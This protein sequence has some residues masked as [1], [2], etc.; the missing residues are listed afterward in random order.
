LKHFLPHFI[1]EHYSAGIF[2][3]RFH[4]ATLFTDLSGFTRLTE[5]LMQ[6]GPEGA[7]ELSVALNQIFQPLVSLVYQQGGMIPY[8]AG[9]SFTAIFPYD[10]NSTW[11]TE[12]VAHN[13]LYTAQQTLRKFM[14]RTETDLEIGVKI[15]IGAGETE[16]GIVGHQGNRSFYFRGDAIDY[17]AN[18]QLAAETLQIIAHASATALL[19]ASG[20]GATPMLDEPF[21][22]VD[23]NINA[24][25]APPQTLAK[26]LPEPSREVL[27]EFY[28]QAV[29]ADSTKTGEFRNVVSAFIA[30]GGVDTHEALQHF[31][32]EILEQ[33]QNFGGY[34]KEID[35]GDKGGVVAVFF[36]AP[37]SYENNLERA[38]EF[39]VALKDKLADVHWIVGATFRIGLTAGTAFTGVIGG[40]ER[41]QYAAVG[42]RVNLAARLM[43]KAAWGEVLADENVQKNRNFKF[44]FRGE[45]QYKGFERNI[46]T[47][48]LSG[49]NLSGPTSYLGTYYGRAGEI[50]AAIEFAR[51][52]R[53]GRF[54]GVIFLFGEA[55]MGKTRLSYE[56]RRQ[57]RQHTEISWFTCQSDQ[58][59]RK[60]FNPFIYFL[61][62]YFE[63]SPENT[64]DRNRALFESNFL[65]LTYDLAASTHPES[66][67]IRHEIT[68]TQSVLAAMISL[69]YPGSLWEQLDARGRY[70]NGMAAMANLF[71]AEAILQPVVIELEDTHW[72]DDM[73]REFLAQF[74]RRATQYP[75]LFLATSRYEDDGSKLHI[76]RT[77]TLDAQQITHLEIDLNFLDNDNLK[78]FA[79]AQLGGEIHPDLFEILQRMTQGNPFY[80]EQMTE[81]FQEANLL[82]HNE[83]GA[84]QLKDQDIQ[85]SDSVKQI[86]MARIDRLSGLVKETVKAAA[87]IG[88]EFDLSV[89][90]A[91]MAKQEEFLRE[92]GNLEL[93][94][95]EQV[96]TAEK[97][98]I[99]HAM[100]ELRYIFRHSLL[101]EAAYDMQLRTRLRELHQMIAETIEAMYPDSSERYVDLAFHYEEAEIPD[102]TN[103]YLEKAAETAKR[104]FQ[105]RS[106][107]KY[108]SKLLDNLP[109]TDCEHHIDM[110]LQR[111]SVYEL[112]GLWD[113]A[114]SDYRNALSQTS[115][116]DKP[117][118]TG[119]CHRFLGH[120]LLLRGNYSD[121]HAH[122]NQSMQF[123]QDAHDDLGVSKTSGNLGS[124]FFRQGQY[125]EAKNWFSKAIDINRA[126]QRESANAEIVANLGLIYMNQGHYDEGI[127]RV[128]EQVDI[129]N[130][131][132]DKSALA[133]L[134]TNLGIIYLEKGSLDSALLCLEKGL[135]L[136]E[137]LGNKLLQTICIGCIGS[138][139]EKKGD[140]PKAMQ[141]FERDLTLCR[142]LGDKQG[143]AI[144]CSLIGELLTHTGQFDQ[145]LQYL[146][147]TLDL[148]F[149]LQYKK[150]IA[151][152]L[153]TLGDAWYF[154]KDYPKAI[155]YY[156]EAIDCARE[157]GNRLVLGYSLI[158]NGIVHLEAGNLHAARLLLDEGKEVAV[159]LGN[160][161][162][163]FGA[164][165]LRAQILMAENRREEVHKLLQH[166][167]SVAKT[168]REEAAVHY[169]LR[170][171]TPETIH[172]RKA[173]HLYAALFQKTPQHFY[174]MRLATLEKEE[175]SQ[176]LS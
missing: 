135:K 40:T 90:S 20:A 105:N 27:A 150:G 16:W 141:N 41:C 103:L 21:L 68:R 159:A 106:A 153:N 13:L 130:R 109:A 94:L 39:A 43:A 108:Y 143:I 22:I 136:S 7:E 149:E 92:N 170:K 118:L 112:I 19:G 36:G 131:S 47:H 173:L 56:V 76:L 110:Q 126:I 129:H 167:L 53:E 163:M 138:V 161:D 166:L 148:S 91:V 79:E 119:E 156:D 83:Q 174:K 48:V 81:Y 74:I 120:L 93:V 142:E 101:R 35:Y 100:N 38:L 146:Q 95:R 145:A 45:I 73:S 72:Y 171:I 96:K 114:E 58:I 64:E 157:M 123:A 57:L 78:A 37:V 121:A 75:I 98:Q 165:I 134:Y 59:L 70:Q 32:G 33:C 69:H 26:P 164:N 125:E 158:E 147:E 115:K 24:L 116:L 6:K 154:K 127:R 1:Q 162:L 82:T 86:M 66:E 28:A 67:A 140:Y 137:E 9:D 155:K 2:H 124:L 25:L 84:L 29:Y 49:R 31:M 104:N 34:L 10:P 18:A 42:A 139:W 87:V 97:W 71:V 15:G 132:E 51:P 8:F 77:Q 23:S 11:D 12:R 52:L 50:Q 152:A 61:K 60:S 160:A 4:A 80:L 117:S 65:E 5:R 175:T 107:L 46:P 169:E 111:G 3:G 30:F 128:E 14:E 54:S 122:F 99:W 55:G 172:R 85:L 62:N 88:R 176:H 133:N 144:A 113:E 102:K 168:P 17:S 151:K 44:Q 89:L 63:Q